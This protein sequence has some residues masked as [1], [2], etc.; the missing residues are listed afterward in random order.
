M[1]LSHPKGLIR[2]STYTWFPNYLVHVSVNEVVF[3]LRSRI[4]E[5]YHGVHSGD[6]GSRA[7]ASMGCFII[8]QAAH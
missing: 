2:R 6:L 8:R 1:R 7:L 4:F 5:L 3:V